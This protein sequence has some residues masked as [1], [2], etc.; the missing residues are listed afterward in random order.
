[1]QWDFDESH[2][3]NQRSVGGER[4]SH[5]SARTLKDEKHILETYKLIGR[6]LT[7]KNWVI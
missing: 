7:S 2:S 6:F 5:S 3:C 4:K 1:M